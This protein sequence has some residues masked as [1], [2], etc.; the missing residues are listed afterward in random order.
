MPWALGERVAENLS[1]LGAI[2]GGVIGNQFGGGF[3]RAAKEFG[4]SE[5]EVVRKVM[6]GDTVDGEFTTVEDVAQ[7]ALFLCTFPSAALTGQSFVVS[8]GWVH[9]VKAKAG[10]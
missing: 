3:G 1:A 8:H 9:A 6:L 2:A 7:T 5:D 10:R 4:I